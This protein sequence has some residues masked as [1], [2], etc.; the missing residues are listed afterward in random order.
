M[1][2]AAAFD[3]GYLRQPLLR[4]LAVDAGRRIQVDGPIQARLLSWHPHV[5]A[6]QVTVANP[7][8][9]PAGNLARIDRL[10]LDL[11]IP[12]NHHWLR[13][14]RLVMEGTSLYLV[15]AADGRANWQLTET[16]Q[17]GGGSL[18]I[19]SLSMLNA[20]ALL[21][22]ERRHL[23][24]DGRI[25]AQGAPDDASPLRLDGVGQLNA[26]PIR[27]EVL[28]DPLASARHDQPYRFSFDERSDTSRL[29]G[30]GALSRAFSFDALEASF[31]AS[32]ENL[33]DF[34][35]LTGISLINTGR[36]RLSG[37]LTRRGTLTTIDDLVATSG[38]SDV[39]GRVLLDT[40]Q[41]RPAL[42]AELHSKILRLSDLGARAA[43]PTSAPSQY[44]LSN[45]ALNP[46]AVRHG[47]A[48]VS[49]QV[50]RM[51]IGRVS[52]QRLAGRMTIDH[53][54]LNVAPL[55]ASLLDGRLDA[56]L[57]MNVSSDDPAD[58]LDLEL[59][60]VQI[61]QL[62]HNP[63]GPPRFEALMNVQVNLTGRGSS[64]HQFAASANG[65]IT[66]SVP[67]GTLRESLA[68][69]SGLDWRGLGLLLTKSQHQTGVRCAVAN[70]EALAGTLIAKNIT[71]DTDDV[72]ISADGSIALGTESLQLAFRGHPKEV[73]LLRLSAPVLLGGT[74]LHPTLSIQHPKSMQ[75]IDPG[76]TPD[77]DCATLLAH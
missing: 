56:H 27:F 60:G 16:D 11:S 61:G 34:Y 13:I 28:S 8:W 12:G 35:A 3:A 40:L 30:R 19:R 52:L 65:S 25:W 62:D 1:G 33:R 32:G 55:S 14:D 23:R 50:D 18:Q 42:S 26:T 9:M 70:F 53:G 77:A 51:D 46:A 48:I 75:L 29:S 69:I 72:L 43:H 59:L 74:L 31:E 67:R 10:T 58:V 64:L 73:R 2:C 20:H 24:F 37:K 47:D 38:I 63:K 22:D 6:E 57:R 68:E 76:N 5:V 41:Q 17:P 44:L 15:R 21:D 66:S 7:S 71:I 39:S 49:V 54:T 4:L 45:A 36:Y